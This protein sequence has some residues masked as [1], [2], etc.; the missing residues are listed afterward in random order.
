[1]ML[2]QIQGPSLSIV[3][4]GASN[5]KDVEMFGKQDPYFRFTLD[6]SEP[7]TF[8]KTFVH[9]NAGQTPVWNQSFEIPL[10]GEPDLFIEIMDEATTADG[11][12]GFAAIPINQVVHAPG[13]TL[14]GFFD[15]F[16]P[17]GT[18]H[19]EV[20]LTLTARNVPGQQMSTPGYPSAPVKGHS[21]IVEAH[22]KR[23]KSL[24][25]K[26]MATDAG[27]AVA[28]GLFAVGAGLLANKIIGDNR[29]EEEERREAEHEEELEHERFEREKR[30]LEEERAAFERT[31]AEEQARLRREHDEL[32]RERERE[33]DDYHDHD[34]GHRRGAI[35]WD[36]CGYYS[37][38][39]MVYYHGREFM[40]L[41][42]HQSNPT[43]QPTEAH[44][45]WRAE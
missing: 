10:N 25:N 19:G 22:Q 3:A 2:S 16:L 28:G 8:Q 24:K 14:C 33:R 35:E 26:E 34:H 38:G 37:A 45:L 31:Q 27:I 23:I 41:Q 1:M 36:P 29:R 4:H 39:D 15:V 21:Y 42:P 12:I 30:R 7:K 40:C 20:S 32:E 44:S 18:P 5:L 13:G 6:I 9:K 17:N 11:V 43:W